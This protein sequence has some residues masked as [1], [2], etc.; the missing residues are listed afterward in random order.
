MEK[1]YIRLSSLGRFC[2][3]YSYQKYVAR[4]ILAGYQL[5]GVCN[6]SPIIDNFREFLDLWEGRT[7]LETTY[8]DGIYSFCKP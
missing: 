7:K 5:L 1:N 8:K 3:K 2:N 6:D 4:E